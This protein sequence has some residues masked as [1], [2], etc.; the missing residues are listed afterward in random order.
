MLCKGRDAFDMSVACDCYAAIARCPS[1]HF[2]L[3]KIG[4]SPAGDLYYSPFVDSISQTGA[5]FDRAS[6]EAFEFIAI[7]SRGIDIEIALVLGTIE[8][9]VKLLRIEIAFFYVPSDRK[10]ASC[11]AGYDDE[12]PSAMGSARR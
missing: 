7:Q 11:A 5:V 6:P 12:S 2:R 1:I 9:D 8:T 3:P 10:E 4:L